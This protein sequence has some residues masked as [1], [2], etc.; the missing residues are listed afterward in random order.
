MKELS[1]LDKKES[2]YLMEDRQDDLKRGKNERF[3]ISLTWHKYS[4]LYFMIGSRYT[5]SQ[6]FVTKLCLKIDN[7][8]EK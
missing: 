8:V 7:T 2:C 5:S 3:A 4:T 1:R 6:R